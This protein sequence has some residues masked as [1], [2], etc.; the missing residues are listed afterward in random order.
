[1]HVD[2]AT[3]FIIDYL[4]KPRDTHGYGSYGYEF[5]LPNVIVAYI[6]EVE[7]SS[8]HLSF[9]YNGQRARELSPVFYEAWDLSRCPA[10]A[11]EDWVNKP[12]RTEQVET[13]FA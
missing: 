2:D 5:Y 3:A 9:L 6:L 10:L 8:E 1:M 4:R 13:A 11:S 12:P 7:H